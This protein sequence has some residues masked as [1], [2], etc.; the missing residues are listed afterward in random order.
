THRSLMG[1][2]A[3]NGWSPR[4]YRTARGAVTAVGLVGA[5]LG[6]PGIALGSRRGLAQRG[7]EP[8]CQCPSDGGLHLFVRCGADR[9]DRPESL[10]QLPAPGRPDPAHVV[11]QAAQAATRTPPAVARERET[12]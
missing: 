3:R 6:R 4:S 5:R 10:Q 8:R 11:E 12:V 7:P 9:L 1:S 2:A